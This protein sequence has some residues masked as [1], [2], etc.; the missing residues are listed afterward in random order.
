MPRIDHRSPDAVGKALVA[1][2]KLGGWWSTGRAEAETPP[3]LYSK[4]S[5]FT[6]SVFGLN[7]LALLY[8]YVVT[9]YGELVQTAE[10]GWVEPLTAALF[11][12]CALTLFLAAAAAGRGWLR[13][14][15]I[16]AGLGALFVVGEELSWGQHIF[17]FA[18]PD[19][20]AG[21]NFQRETNF[22]N[23]YALSPIFSFFYYTLPPLCYALLLAA[24]YVR[25]Y[26]FGALPL[27]SL[28][29][30]FFLA[31]SMNFGSAVTFS[32]IFALHGQHLLLILGI[33]LGIALLSRDKRLLT[34]VA[35]ITILSGAAFYLSETFSRYSQVEY[36]EMREYL[37]GLTAFLY[38]LQLL[39]DSG[40]GRWQSYGRRVKKL[41]DRIGA[42][43]A[44]E[45][46]RPPRRGW[47]Y[48]SW[49]WA[50]PA[51]CLLVALSSIGLVFFDRQLTAYWGLEYQALATVPPAFQSHFWNIYHTPGR[52]TYVK[53]AAC[54]RVRDNEPRFFLHIVPVHE[55]DLP[56]AARATGFANLNFNYSNK[57]ERFLSPDGRC[58][59]VIELPDYPIAQIETGQHDLWEARLWTARLYLDEPYYRAAY[60]PI[61]AGQAGP[62]LARAEFDL[63]R[64]NN[65]L[66]YFRESCAPADTEAR[67]FLHIYPIRAADLPAA[68]QP[69]RFSNLDFD[70]NRR[71]HWFDGKC[72]AVVELPDYPVAEIRTGQQVAAA[73]V[74]TTRL[75]LAAE[76]Y[77]AAY[78]PI[79]AGQAGPPLA[80]AEFDLYRYDNSLYYFREGCA[81][82]DTAARFF[83]HLIPDNPEDLAAARRDLGFAN[84]DFDFNRRG[85]WFDGK[86]LAVVELPDWPIAEIRTGQF[87]AGGTVWEAVL[88]A[89]N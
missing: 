13:R 59:A 19:F 21:F 87:T 55:T 10:T 60:Q 32:R 39:R 4:L 54:P 2:R 26:R 12:G 50:W 14:F 7:V 71:G 31:L 8:F 25:K 86:C 62:P 57:V 52:L 17:G 66:Y 84:R 34:G 89:G 43:P 46:P 18:N 49:R 61:A 68:R 37:F 41:I 81:P 1:V 24:F 40:G 48:H 69:Q 42:R 3:G 88:P 30:T 33:F 73:P 58:M 79:A 64:Y 20:L 67:F 23:T 11:G 36:P 76:H 9:G 56:R 80:R 44:T 16:L 6:F 83:L 15:Y 63:Y 28:W 75:N 72:L 38:S 51:A 77:R 78:Q 45:N 70:F 53:N 29:L 47:E 27:P 65:A 35:S 74:W 22:H 82:A 85:H 5:L